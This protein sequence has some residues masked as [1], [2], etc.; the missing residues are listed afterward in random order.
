[1]QTYFLFYIFK[2]NSLKS[3]P[4]I[5]PDYK[6]GSWFKIQLSKPPAPDTHSQNVTLSCSHPQ[7]PWLA[8]CPVCRHSPQPRLML[9]PSQS[10]YWPLR[11]C[12]V[13][14]PHHRD[15]IPPPILSSPPPPRC[16]PGL[17]HVYHRTQRKW[18]S[19]TSYIRLHR[20]DTVV[21]TSLTHSLSPSLFLTLSRLTC[22]RRD[23]PAHD[24]Q[25]YGQ[26]HRTRIWSLLPTPRWVYLEPQP[27]APVEPLD[28]SSPGNLE[29]QRRPWAKIIQ[30]SYSW[31][32]YSQKLW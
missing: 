9:S 30:L 11:F 18:W 4:F 15:E 28:N 25:P 14:Y 31:I 1:M 13:E 29:P 10:P 17:V 20:K 19:I 21:S 7:R 27:L 23:Q 26:A 22:S 3:S 12:P 24:T 16:V 6:Q 5:P 32:P 8:P 2:N